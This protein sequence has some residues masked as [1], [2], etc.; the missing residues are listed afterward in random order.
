MLVGQVN[1]Q[2]DG[3]EEFPDPVALQAVKSAGDIEEQ[4]LEL[5][6]VSG[7]GSGILFDEG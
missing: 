6:G 5:M 1:A 7:H 4:H 3:S 2:V